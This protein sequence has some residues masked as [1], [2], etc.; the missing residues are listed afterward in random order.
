MSKSDTQAAPGF[1]IRP[2]ILT[3]Y[4]PSFLLAF[5]AAVLLPV[6]PIFA[7]D[8]LGAGIAMIGIAVAA[9]EIG[10]MIF[11]VPA[12]LLVARLGTK[13]TMLLGVGVFSASAV[14]AAISFDLSFLLVMRV[15]AGLG[16]A[17]WTISR[18]AYIAQAVPA[19]S[20][21][22]ALSLFGG[23]GR[24]ATI[25]GPLAGGLLGKYVGL[26]SAFYLQAGVGV[27]T[28]VLVLATLEKS[29]PVTHHGAKVFASLGNTVVEY[30]REFATA[31]LAAIALQLL[32]SSRQLLIPLWGLDIGLDV[33]QIGYITSMSSAIDAAMFVPAGYIMDRWGRRWTGG[34]S[35]VIMAIGL[36][37]LPLSHSFWSLTLVGIVAGLGNGLSSG[38]VLTMGADIAPK[39]RA[40]EF[41]GVWR[42]I[43]D[44]GGA[45]GPLVVGG[46]ARALTL[47]AASLVTSG[48]GVLGFLV[49]V[50]LVQET[51]EA[52]ER[53]AARKTKGPD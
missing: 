24:I 26:E 8:E 29:S 22:R 3:V 42:L 23:L 48:V 44:S 1:S 32:R 39:D 5:G 13:R 2:L 10:T 7:K 17:L 38:L 52:E 40:G 36:M 11:D 46:I 15:A 34:P 20:R 53:H 25:L 27:A 51:T 4:A 21:G 35:M 18:H 9:R 19:K 28:M 47:S 6:L 33:G 41:L 37:L 45:A 50:L 30:R 14:G 43:T 12:G 49:M 16:M 31:G